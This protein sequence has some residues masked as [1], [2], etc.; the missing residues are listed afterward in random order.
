[1]SGTKIKYLRDN[2][3]SWAYRRRVPEKHQKTL[4][5]KMWNRPCGNV[6]FQKAVALVTQWAE[7]HDELLYKLDTDHKYA[8]QLRRYTEES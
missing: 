7:K 2:N 5:F 6:S 8:G 1:M 3:G 4:G